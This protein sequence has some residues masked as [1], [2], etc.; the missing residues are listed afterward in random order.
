MRRESG[1]EAA[2]S[3]LFGVWDSP[4][5]PAGSRTKSFKSEQ[6][7]N[8]KC[9]VRAGLVTSRLLPLVLPCSSLTRASLCCC[10]RAVAL[11]LRSPCSLD[12]FAARSPRRAPAHSPAQ[13]VFGSL[14]LAFAS[15]ARSMVFYVLFALLTLCSGQTVSP[16]TSPTPFPMCSAPPGYFCSGGSA[17]IC[18][19][20]AY[21]AGGAALNVSC[22]P[23]TACTIAGLSAQPP[24]Y[25]NV[26][27]IAGRG[28]LG[29]ANGIGTNALFTNLQALA[30]DGTET[31]YVGDRDA[32]NV[33]KFNLSS[34]EV[35][36]FAA[37]PS[38][39]QGVAVFKQS[40]IASTNT[41]ADVRIFS[42]AGSIVYTIGV[43]SWVNG[44]AFNLSGNLFTTNTVA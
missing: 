32:F 24:C 25:W 7:L 1:K 19:I 6:L 4:G 29:S 33:K 39:V 16:T 35:K 28:T 15:F 42:E 27:T 36:S 9:P 44:M 34:R 14:A 13:T 37:L 18:P 10:C 22:Y 38:I 12:I 20:G 5:P 30:F 40:R 2:V 31:L 17:L 23:V 11:W 43:T 26:S 21:C 8:L 41:N 3:S